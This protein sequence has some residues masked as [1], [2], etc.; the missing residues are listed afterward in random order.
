[1]TN[2]SK[3]YASKT[4]TSDSEVAA[5][6]AELLAAGN[7]LRIAVGDEA[8][9]L[10]LDVAESGRSPAED[11]ERSISGIERAAGSW[12]DEDTDAFLDYIYRC[13]SM[14]PRPAVE[15]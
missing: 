3:T 10:K 5:L 12:K 1:M 15:L 7:E 13:R 8:Y 11:V 14:S 6:V 2:A 4:Y 9:T